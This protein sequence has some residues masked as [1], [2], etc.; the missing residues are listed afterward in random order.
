MYTYF[1]YII[2]FFKE[3]ETH[4]FIE[5]VDYYDF[6][7]FDFFQR[8]PDGFRLA[9]LSRDTYFCVGIWTSPPL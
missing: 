9:M 3:K 7:A 2:F 5:R 6:P 1:V 8:Q 4:S